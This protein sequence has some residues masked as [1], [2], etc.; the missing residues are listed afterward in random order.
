MSG[1]RHFAFLRAINTGNRRLT[2]EQLLAPFVGLGFTDVAA[3]QAAGNVTFRCDDPAIASHDTIER[4]LAKAY[5]FEA[6]IFMR[7]AAQVRAIVDA[8]PFT[9][10]SIDATAGKI[11][12]A[13]LRRAPS[14]DV[15]DLLADLVPDDDLVRVIGHEWY[16][17]PVEGI[18]T[19]SLPVS[20]V[21]SLLGEMTMRTLGTIERMSTKFA[22]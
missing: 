13:F 2:N 4:A 19:S 18:S 21:G 16:W 5:G 7:S 11:Q 17:L 12:V 15:V 22:D 9:A 1:D 8:R 3:Y 10:E 6:P 14:P 20:E